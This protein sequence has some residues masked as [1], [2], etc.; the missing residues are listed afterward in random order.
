[1]DRLEEARRTGTWSSALSTGAFA[2]VRSVGFEPV[3]QVMGSAV[4]HVGRAG[5]YWGY[6]DCLYLG[7]GFTMPGAPAPG[8]RR[9]PG[10]PVGAP[11]KVFDAARRTALNRLTAECLALGGDG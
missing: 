3:G 8:G 11:V 7:I 5:R 4:Y 6:Y 9:A 1:M 10:P 2:S